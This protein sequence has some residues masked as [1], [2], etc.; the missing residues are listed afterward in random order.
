M[1]KPVNYRGQYKEDII[2]IAELALNNNHLL[3]T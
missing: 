3:M 1:G 2:I